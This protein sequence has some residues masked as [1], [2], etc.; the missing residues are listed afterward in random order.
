MSD[1]VSTEPKGEGWLD[2]VLAKIPDLPMRRTRNAFD[3]LC[4]SGFDHLAFSLEKETHELVNESEARRIVSDALAQSVAASLGSDAELISRASSTWLNDSLRITENRS[5]V[6]EA[7]LEEFKQS[8]SQGRAFNDMAEEGQDEASD[9]DPD[10]LNYFS[11]Y[12]GKATTDYARKLW[13]KVLASEIKNDGAI[14]LATMRVISELS[15]KQAEWITEFRAH[16]FGDFLFFSKEYK[17]KYYGNFLTLDELGIIK[18][19]DD[20]AKPLRVVD[21]LAEF[22]PYNHNFIV[23]QPRSGTGSKSIYLRATPVT[24]VGIEIFRLIDDQTSRE[25]A[26]ALIDDIPKEDLELIAIGRQ[27]SKDQVGVVE[28]IW[29]RT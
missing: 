26:L 14:S 19:V 27:L 23:L 5:A 20:V 25:S 17:E 1:I 24:N 13:G 3:R 22:I 9:I 15:R 7:A 6:A 18:T 4:A 21:D 28:V 29:K 10:W 2:K 11:E 16:F 8:K 12:A